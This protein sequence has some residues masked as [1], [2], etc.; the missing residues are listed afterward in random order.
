[1][2]PTRAVEVRFRRF[3]L[4]D[5]L[6]RAWPARE[7]D[8]APARRARDGGR[9]IIRP[10]CICFSGA[11]SANTQVAF[12]SP[13]NALSGDALNLTR[14]ISTLAYSARASSSRIGSPGEQLRDLKAD[15]HHL[16][17]RMPSREHVLNGRDFGAGQIFES[18]SRQPERT[19]RRRVTTGDG[20]DQEHGDPARPGNMTTRHARIISASDSPAHPPL[21]AFVKYFTNGPIQT[22]LFSLRLRNRPVKERQSSRCGILKFCDQPVIPAA[23]IQPRRCVIVPDSPCAGMT[24]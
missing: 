1:M 10:S 7:S 5:R 21:A 13:R 8:R 3:M 4:I 16:L 24:G 20:R 2:L 17:P 19:S 14:T 11:P 22:R 12:R 9:G 6:A 23:R 15:E 18:R